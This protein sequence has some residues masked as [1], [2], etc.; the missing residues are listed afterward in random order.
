MVSVVVADEL[1][2]VGIVID[3]VLEDETFVN[4]GIDLVDV[5]DDLTDELEDNLEDDL[6][7][8]LEV[9][10]LVRYEEPD[11]EELGT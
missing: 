4:G 6:E 5:E 10:P 1:V 2:L 9:D 3:V 7:D 8:E 11:D